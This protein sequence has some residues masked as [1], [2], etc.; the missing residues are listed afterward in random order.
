MASNTPTYYDSDI[1]RTPLVSEFRNL[2]DY[3]GLIWLLTRRDLTVRYKRSTLGLWWTLLNPLL[4]TFILWMVFGQFFR[5]EIPGTPYV[6][7]LLSG[8]LLITYFAQAVQASGAAIVNNAGILTK[9]F[10]PAEVF[11]FSTVASAT[12]NFLI[13]L[14]PMAI[15]QLITGV[16]IPWTVIL[17]PIPIMAMFAL[18][19]GIGLLVA[20][21][22]VFFYDV[23][24]LTAVMIQLVSYMTPTFYPISIVPEWALPIIYLNPLFSYLEVFRGF[25]YQG[26]FAPAWNF[27]YMIVSAI[28]SLL[29]GVYV[30][31]RSWRNLIA[32]L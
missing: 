3:R 4:T 28:V 6:V 2:W 12:V 11:S 25:M 31:S 17:V 19:A 22:A 23:L 29:I 20:A 9:V 27:A 24:D 8:I 15:I 30:F 5:F 7:Y 10:V 21:A 26:T 13:S 16:G 32:V 14:L 1:S 18:T